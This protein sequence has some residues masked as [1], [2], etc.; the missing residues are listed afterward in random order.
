MNYVVV[1]SRESEDTLVDLVPILTFKTGLEA[2]SRS[3]ILI[4]VVFVGRHIF[5]FHRDDNSK[6]VD[7]KHL[8]DCSACHF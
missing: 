5:T 8:I 1:R 4:F 2:R 7:V 3:V 6:T